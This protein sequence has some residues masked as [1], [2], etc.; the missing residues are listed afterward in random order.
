MTKHV[1][2][3]DVGDAETIGDP[4]R[5]GALTGSRWANEEQS[6]VVDSLEPWVPDFA[7]RC[8]EPWVRGPEVL[9]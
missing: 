4:G 3:G 1:T 9:K 6:H 7:E 2:S 8:W 5:L